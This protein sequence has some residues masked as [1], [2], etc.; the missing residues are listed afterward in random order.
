MDE[1]DSAHILKI[2]KSS[3]KGMTVTDISK[4][5]GYNRNSTAKQ[6]EVFLAEGKVEVRTIGTA[7][8]YSLARRVPL[9]AFL[10]FA[11]N[12]ILILDEDWNI[13]QVNDQYLKI[14][15]IPKQDLIGRDFFRAAPPIVSSQEGITAIRSAGAEQVVADIRH[16]D[17]GYERFY[18]MEVIP[19]TFEDG[20]NG[21]TI[22]LEDITS[23]KKYL[24]NL[25]FLATTS[26]E[27]A[28]MDEKDNIYQYIADKIA[29]LVPNAHI[30]VDSIDPETKISKTRAISSGD[31]QFLKDFEEYI[32]QLGN[33]SDLSFDTKNMPYAVDELKKGSIIRI[34][35]SFYIMTWG[36]LPEE[37]C[38]TVEKNLKME[39]Y[40]SIGCSCRGGLY[41]S[42]GFRFRKGDDLTNKE[43]IEAFVKQAGIALQ[44][45]FLKLKLRHVQ[46]KLKKCEENRQYL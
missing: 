20:T 4:K 13:I 41:G 30:N 16:L 27:L 5:I 28:N 40:Y 23:E 15:G 42:V 26:A 8:V 38:N 25:E 14:A 31:P 21:T 35:D 6:L 39:R 3:P 18:R 36:S 2:L 32:A 1:N 9:S 46:E 11:K 10:C 44:R 19:T 34:P 24:N 37:W 29:Y 12:M 33:I 43:I 22:I 45:R 7:R 17:G